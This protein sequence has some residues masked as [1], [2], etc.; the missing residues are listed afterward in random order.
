MSKHVAHVSIVVDIPI[1]RCVRLLHLVPY[2]A[3]LTLR[4]GKRKIHYEQDCD[5]ECVSVSVSATGHEYDS[6]T[7]DCLRDYE[8]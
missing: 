4:D 5:C 3:L 7:S 1:N 6:T 2:I 8:R